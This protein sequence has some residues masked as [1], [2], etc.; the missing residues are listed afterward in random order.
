MAFNGPTIKKKP[1]TLQTVML[2]FARF[3]HALLP[4]RLPTL[5]AVR[6]S[7][8]FPAAEVLPSSARNHH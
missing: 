4:A 2:L 5:A 7:F 3:Q 8:H 1:L 6:K